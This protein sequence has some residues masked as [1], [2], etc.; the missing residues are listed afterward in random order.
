M[1]FRYLEDFISVLPLGLISIISSSTYHY[2]PLNTNISIKPHSGQ[3]RQTN[4]LRKKD[5]VTLTS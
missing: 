5:T 4:G 1:F 2:F 3:N